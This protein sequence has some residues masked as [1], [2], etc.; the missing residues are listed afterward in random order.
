MSK[1][2]RAVS[3]SKKTHGGAPAFPHITPIQQLRR[4]VLS[5]LLWESNF[6]EDGESIA[7]RIVS[8]A[9]KVK[10]KELQELIIEARTQYHL[11]HVSLLLLCA[12]IKQG[13][14]GVADTI[15]ETI[16]RADELTELL[17]I[18]WRN[19]R[20]P[21]SAQMKKGLAKA[22]TKFDAYNLAK[23]NKPGAIKLRDVLFLIHAKP[24]DKVQEK[25]WKQ[26]VDD[27]LPSPDTWEVALSAGEDKQKSFDRLLREGKLGYMALLR[28]LR[29]MVE[30]GVDKDLIKDAILARK[31]AHN[32]LPFRYVAAA[33][34]CPQLERTLDQA[35]VA[36]VGEAEQFTGET[37]ILVDVSGSMAWDVS[38]KSQMKLMDIAATLA[39]VF[40]GA[41]RIFT[42]SNQMVEV[43]QRIGMA[44]VDAIINSQPYGGTDLAKAV[45]T[46][47]K[48]TTFDR[49]IV[50]TDEQVTDE[51]ATSYIRVPDPVADKAYMINVACHQNGI[52]YGKWTHI[53][54]FSEGVL[55]WIREVE[56]L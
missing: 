15:N 35:L 16:R 40:P 28:N 5:C 55:R 43:P 54:G 7:D 27:T 46:I 8:Y 19:G 18:Y 49:L 32:V 10:K 4:S 39:S 33:R 37:A 42:F 13:G 14:E 44:G 2:N 1:L 25:T 11:R 21:L 17:A 51:Q 6:Y 56:A 48:A 3:Y 30:S 38:A 31:G 47:N 36:S 22:F 24:Q 52:G 45:E 29:N 9:E 12:L 20:R 23:Y 53:D 50:I 26:L 34:A 41:A